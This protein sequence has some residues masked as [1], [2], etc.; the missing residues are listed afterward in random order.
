VDPPADNTLT[1]A[2]SVSLSLAGAAAL[3][4]G[5]FWL[6]RRRRARRAARGLDLITKHWLDVVWEPSP[7]SP[8]RGEALLQ[9]ASERSDGLDV[10]EG[11]PESG[12]HGAAADAFQPNLTPTPPLDAAELLPVQPGAAEAD[13]EQHPPPPPEAGLAQTPPSPSLPP[14]A[15]DDSPQASLLAAGERALAL[16]PASAEMRSLLSRVSAAWAASARAARAALHADACAAL[17][18]A[19]QGACELRSRLAP[20]IASVGE[21]V[22]VAD[23]A[24]VLAVIQLDE[25]LEQAAV[26]ATDAAADSLP[27][28]PP[29]LRVE[30]AKALTRSIELGGGGET[31]AELRLCLEALVYPPPSPEEAANTAAAAAFA[32]DAAAALCEEQEAGSARQRCAQLVLSLL[33]QLADGE[34]AECGGVPQ[35]D[36]ADNVQ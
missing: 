25:A 1:I 31:L 22:P 4:G 18:D 30:T 2:L 8:R 7:L 34:A 6:R 12:D 10:R 3:V 23:E 9:E 14:P 36:G 20:V 17:L 26:A 11:P 29:S 16:L 27:R 24:A 32:L 5:A 33:S 15:P 35:P 19:L 13:Q 28:A 21:G